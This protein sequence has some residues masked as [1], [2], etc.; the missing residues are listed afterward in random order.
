[1]EWAANYP[2]LAEDYVPGQPTD[3]CTYSQTSGPLPTQTTGDPHHLQ[4]SQPSPGGVNLDAWLSV[5]PAPSQNTSQWGPVVSD[6][7]DYPN[8]NPRAHL[9]S[10]N[11]S[12]PA[13]ASHP[14]SSFSHLPPQ[15]QPNTQNTNAI[16]Q[17]QKIR[18][19]R[20]T[21]EYAVSPSYSSASS[22]PPPRPPPHHH[23]KVAS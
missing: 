18:Q 19:R 1:M 10:S 11:C 4:L 20:R 17:R 21:T 7:P 14:F 5:I 9:R 16:R 12:Q 2:H 6:S 3:F 23:H 22:P 13:D 15:E 8:P